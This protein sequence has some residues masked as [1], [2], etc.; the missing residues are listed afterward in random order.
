MNVACSD[1]KRLAR[2]GAAGLALQFGLV[3]AIGQPA[4][5]TT[6]LETNRLV[7]GASTR[8]HV[9]AHIADAERDHVQQIFSWD[10]DLLV[11]SNAMVRIDAGQLV[12][13]RSDNDPQ[14]SSSGRLQGANLLDVHD[15]FLTLTNAGLDEPVEL[16]SVPLVASA[17]GDAQVFVQPGTGRAETGGDV[18]L[19]P[20]GDGAPLIG[21][22]YSGAAGWL[23]VDAPLQSVTAGIAQTLLPGGHGRL[24]TISFPTSPGNDYTVEY[25]SGLDPGAVWEPLPAAPHNNGFA[26]DTNAVPARFYR[27]RTV[28]TR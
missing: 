24:I 13:P 8:L 12:R 22:D 1:F 27:V 5:V 3:R 23:H 10:L 21:A 17:P 19:A 26:D 2:V 14:L 6:T 28:R 16:F 15:T 4:V 7:V 18:V 25:R 9:Y 11:S 20:T